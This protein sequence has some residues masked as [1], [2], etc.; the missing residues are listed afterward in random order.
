MSTELAGLHHRI[1]STMFYVTHDQSE[2]MRANGHVNVVIILSDG[3]G[4]TAI[5][6]GETHEK[7]KL[8]DGIYNRWFDDSIFCR[9]DPDNVRGRVNN[10]ARIAFLERHIKM[11]RVPLRLVATGQ[12]EWRPLIASCS[13]L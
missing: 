10:R 12:L 4:L 9:R 7:T 2:E 3:Y 1:K 5:G 11:V 6:T 13:G 8:F